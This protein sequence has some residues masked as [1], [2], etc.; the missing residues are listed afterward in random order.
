VLYTRFSTERSVFDGVTF[1]L[2]AWKILV[3]QEEAVVVPDFQAKGYPVPEFRISHRRRR[4][5]A[6]H[7]SAVSPAF[8]LAAV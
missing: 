8:A 7:S 4:K 1:L 6:P 2:D 3:E 5:C